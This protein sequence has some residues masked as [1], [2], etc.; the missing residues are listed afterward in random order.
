MARGLLVDAGCGPQREL[1]AAD[2]SPA[3]LELAEKLRE[4]GGV[5]RFRLL[6]CLPFA[7]TLPDYSVDCIFSVQH[8]QGIGESIDKPFGRRP[9]FD[10]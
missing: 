2:Y 3:L 8:R 6:R 10:G 1:F 5:R 9:H 4:P 7:I